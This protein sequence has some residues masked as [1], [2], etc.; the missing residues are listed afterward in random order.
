MTLRWLREG[1]PA[2]GLFAGAAA[3]LVSTQLNYALVPWVCATGMSW[4]TPALSA[5]LMGVG[6]AGGFLSWRAWGDADPASVE[7]SAVA[8]P[9]RFLAGI[10]V[11][12]AALFVL[13]IA[14]Q[15][16]AAFLLQGC[17]R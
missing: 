8:H 12:S 5:M 3:W 1:I 2:A 17:E 11:L 10:G 7:E 9:R 6:F 14:S 15:G 4:V 16:S 13:V